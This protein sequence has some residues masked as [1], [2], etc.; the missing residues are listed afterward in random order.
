MNDGRNILSDDRVKA[1][2]EI[3]EQQLNGAGQ[4]YAIP[5][6]GN[7]KTM[8]AKTALE[9][10]M[11]QAQRIKQHLTET[12][13]TPSTKELLEGVRLPEMPKPSKATREA[14][15][16][17]LCE[18]EHDT[19]L[20]RIAEQ[21]AWYQWEIESTKREAEL[22][23]KRAP[24]IAVDFDGTLCENEW[25]GIGETKWETV[26]ALI[27]ARAAGA[28]LVLWTNRVGARLREAVEWCRN[29]ELEFDA[30]N[31]NLPEVLA[32]FT[33]DCRK[34]YADIYLDD[35]AA[36][37]SAAVLGQLWETAREAMN[38]AATAEADKKTK[39]EGGKEQ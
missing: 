17:V 33:T 10:A 11:E 22:A 8:A 21:A 16:T 3:I 39:P 24:I 34:V 5:A 32:A 1:L 31:E 13:R 9:R 2:R 38:E 26:Q 37:P 7:C 6:R 29:R 15:D 36:Q 19:G 23:K 28:R 27:A 14:Y 30:V 35:R 12:W 20:H 25:P 18:L 4:V